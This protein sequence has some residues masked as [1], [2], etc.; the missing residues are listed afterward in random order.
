MPREVLAAL[1]PAHSVLDCTL[2]GGGH[3]LA[4]L[5]AGKRV[6]GIDRDPD[7]LDIA[8]ARLGEYTSR[9]AFHAV[10]GDFTRLGDIAELDGACFDGILADLGVSSWQLDSDTRGFSFRPGIAL[11]MRMTSEGP[12]AADFLNQAPAEALERAFREYGDEPRGRRLAT[13]VIRRRDRREFRVSDDFVDAIRGALGA[14]TG[15]SDFARL[16]QA[17]RI[18]VNDELDGL[19]RALPELRD[20]LKAGGTLAVIAYHSGEDRLVK[21][22]MRDWSVACTCPPRQ[23]I[24]I[25]AGIALGA[26]ATRKAQQ[27]GAMEMAANPRS[28]SARMRVWRKRA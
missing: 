20:R 21:H 8:A 2:G 5:Q 13:E 11:D 27:A 6:T 14:S 18:T 25:C 3:A 28:R 22:A 16:F 12:T 1:S 7:A 10:E 4:L 24:C 17:L 15:P 19:E 9:G 23:P 26:L